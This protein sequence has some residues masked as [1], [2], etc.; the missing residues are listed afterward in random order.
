MSIT[1]P[2]PTAMTSSQPCLESQLCR[3]VHQADRRFLHNVENQASNAGLAQLLDQ[4]LVPPAV[5]AH[6]KQSSA[7]HAPRQIG[8]E[9]G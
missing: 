4:G 5:S 6:D 2:P 8:K 9:L 3:F 7:A 1:L